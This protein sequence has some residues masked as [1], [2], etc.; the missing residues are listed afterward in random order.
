MH[1]E[2]IMYIGQSKKFSY[3]KKVKWQLFSSEV[4]QLSYVET[5]VFTNMA[6][7]KVIRLEVCHALDLGS[8]SVR[9]K[10]QY[11]EIGIY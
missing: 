10:H 1:R 11:E 9:N 3:L 6:E 4:F 5:L 8:F 7:V 2:L